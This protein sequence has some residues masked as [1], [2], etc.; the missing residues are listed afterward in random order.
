MLGA[1]GQPPPAGPYRTGHQRNAS[2]EKALS[3]DILERISNDLPSD[4]PPPN[5]WQRP[6]QYRA[7]DGHGGGAA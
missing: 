2:L 6:E 4:L 1:N 3:D 7:L 5:H